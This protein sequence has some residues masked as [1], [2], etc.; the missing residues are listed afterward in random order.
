LLL[1]NIAARCSAAKG[2]SRLSAGTAASRALPSARAC[3][4]AQPR[5]T[6]AGNRR[7]VTGALVD[8]AERFVGAAAGQQIRDQQQSPVE[9]DSAGFIRRATLSASAVSPSLDSRAY[10][11]PREVEIGRI[12][13]ANK[14]NSRAA[15][16]W[17]P[18]GVSS[19]RF[20]EQLRA[21]ARRGHR[22]GKQQ[23][24]YQCSATC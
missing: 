7:R 4:L 12:S 10:R 9:P 15:R 8:D 11:P 22:H 21:G 20:D 17:S 3:C 5:S 1:S 18:H 14:A 6:G 23:R 16:A 24:C 2:A 13:P 19:A